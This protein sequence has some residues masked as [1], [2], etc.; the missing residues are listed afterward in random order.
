[1]KQIRN[2]IE[3]VRMSSPDEWDLETTAVPSGIHMVDVLDSPTRMDDLTWN[4]TAE[5]VYEQIAADSK[6]T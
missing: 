2:K 5:L 4:W 3:K 1:M 6:K